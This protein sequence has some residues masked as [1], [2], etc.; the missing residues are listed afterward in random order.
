MIDGRVAWPGR[1]LI[2]EGIDTLGGTFRQRLNA[3]VLQVP[4]VAH[5]LMPGGSSLRKET[6]ADTL[7]ITTNEK[8]ARYSRHLDSNS[9]SYR[10]AW[11]DKQSHLI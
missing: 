6:K 10:N 5:H 2:F 4:D 1:Q 8:P 11:R 7:H 3:S 9:I